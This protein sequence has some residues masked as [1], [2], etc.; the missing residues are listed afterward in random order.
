MAEVKFRRLLW[1]ALVS[2]DIQV[3]LSS[4]LPPLID[5]SSYSI[6]YLSEAPEAD[7]TRQLPQRRSS[8]TILGLLVGGKTRFVQKANKFLHILHSTTLSETD[9]DEILKL[10]KEIEREMA[11]RQQQIES[12]ERTLSQQTG[13]ASYADDESIIRRAEN[14]RV[15]GRFA[16]MML[17]LL[18]M[19]PYAIICGPARRHGLL[20]YLH[21]KVPES[22]IKPPEMRIEEGKIY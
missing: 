7:F 18:A 16:R 9:M 19:K 2:I 11:S 4:G 3:A 21:E 6:N 17:S 1:W 20:S 8:K 15:F 13:E 5:C 22:V 12:I 10:S 14:S